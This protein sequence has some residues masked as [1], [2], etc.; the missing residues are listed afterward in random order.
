MNRH[1]NIGFEVMINLG[2]LAAMNQGNGAWCSRLCVV[3]D[4]PTVGDGEDTAGVVVADFIRKQADVCPYLNLAGGEAVAEATGN[5]LR[6]FADS[7]ETDLVSRWGF[8]GADL[9]AV[10][11]DGQKDKAVIRIQPH[12]HQY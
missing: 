7:V 1:D 3:I 8:V 11:Y 4:V 2:T 9:N 6:E 12:W 5:F 10:N